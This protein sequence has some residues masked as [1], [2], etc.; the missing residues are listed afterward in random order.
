MMAMVLCHDTTSTVALV[1]SWQSAFVGCR[2]RSQFIVRVSGISPLTRT[3]FEISRTFAPL[4]IWGPQALEIFFL[5]F[6]RRSRQNPRKKESPN[7][8]GL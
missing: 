5:G 2:A 1:V 6:W 7:Q 4:E 8:K 3:L